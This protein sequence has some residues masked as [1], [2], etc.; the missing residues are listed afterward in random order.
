MAAGSDT[1]SASAQEAAQLRADSDKG[2]LGQHRSVRSRI[3]VSTA[4]TAAGSQLA[5]AAQ[6]LP[7]SEA[8]L[9]G[10]TDAATDGEIAAG[11]DWFQPST[12]FG[13]V[14]K[15]PLS[16][17]QPLVFF[18]LKALS[19]SPEEAAMRVGLVHDHGTFPRCGPLGSTTQSVGFDLQSG[20]LADG[21]NQAST[22]LDCSTPAGCGVSLGFG[23]VYDEE[24]P[25]KPKQLVLLR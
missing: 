24:D 6:A 16:R 4:A 12:L 5:G 19:D 9:Q 20:Q 2:L 14:W 15:N 8:V 1:T 23:A 22:W 10:S 25:T 7:H 3:M 11:D 17:A 18:T 21:C 13:A